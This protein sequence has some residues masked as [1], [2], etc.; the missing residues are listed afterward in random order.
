M[1]PCL[2]VDAPLCADCSIIWCGPYDGDTSKELLM[3]GNP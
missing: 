3:V 2:G 1:V